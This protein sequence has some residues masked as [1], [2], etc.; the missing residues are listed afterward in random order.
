M[1]ERLR[2]VSTFSPDLQAGAQFTDT[3][4]FL[5]LPFIP[6]VLW[7]LLAYKLFIDVNSDFGDSDYDILMALLVNPTGQLAM[8]TGGTR[9]Q[10]MQRPDILD[11]VVFRRECNEATAVGQNTQFGHLQPNWVPTDLL[12]PK[13]GLLVDVEIA[14]ASASA[15]VKGGVCLEYEKLYVPFSEQARHSL[16]FGLTVEDVFT[17]DDTSRWTGATS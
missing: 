8:G 5:S 15:R 11:M 10:R 16:H 17:P 1:P 2:K 9:M 3:F 14:S 7:R 13:L 4:N 12:V 6:G